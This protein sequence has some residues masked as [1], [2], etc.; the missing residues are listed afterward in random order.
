MTISF[1]HQDQRT[2]EFLRTKTI[3]IIEIKSLFRVAISMYR[4]VCV[5]IYIYM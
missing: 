2:L 5:C 1:G 4:G 3:Q